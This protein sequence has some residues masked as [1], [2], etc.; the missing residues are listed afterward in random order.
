[1]FGE[2]SDPCSTWR[3][4]FGFYRDAAI[5]EADDNVLWTNFEVA[6]FE[7]DCALL[8]QTTSSSLLPDMRPAVI[9]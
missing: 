7:V 1:M 2:T 4:V 3:T 6:V 9:Y 5:H 8:S